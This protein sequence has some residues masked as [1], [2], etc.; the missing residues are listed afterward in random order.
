MITSI[1][2]SPLERPNTL[3]VL[4]FAETRQEVIYGLVV[5]SPPS[6]S[7]I[8]IEA[9]MT[10]GREDIPPLGF[11]TLTPLPGPNVGE[12]PP[13][14]ASIFIVMSPKNMPLTNR[15]S[16]LA[17]PNLVISPAFV[18][19]NYKVL[20]YLLRDHR[21]QVHKEYLHTE[22]DYYSEEY[23]EEE[24]EGTQRPVL[25]GKLLLSFERGPHMFEDIREGL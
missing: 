19:A 7:S 12:L 9:C 2:I 16:T 25:Q 17:N 4:R 8:T 20:E 3:M 11:S 13:I 21:R 10:S 22:L 5:Q 18:E 14:T 24:N 1:G 6:N 15:A 23:D